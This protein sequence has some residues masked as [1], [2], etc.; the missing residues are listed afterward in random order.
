MR[1]IDSY[2]VSEKEA[3]VKV[4]LGKNALVKKLKNL[5]KKLKKSH[6]NTIYEDL[7]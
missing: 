3:K 2:N 1:L 5:V 7:I 6:D 4:K